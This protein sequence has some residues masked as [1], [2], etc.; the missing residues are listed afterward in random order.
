MRNHHVSLGVL[1]ALALAGAG[2]VGAS[3]QPATGTV[4]VHLTGTASSGTVYRLREAI[5]TVDGP[6]PATF[7]TEDDPTRTSLSAD[8]EPGD[9]TATVQ[10]GWHIERLDDGIATEVN[11]TLTSDNP[12]HFTVV[13]EQR[14]NVPL[15]FHVDGGDVDLTQGY[16]ITL[17]ID[18]GIPSPGDGYQV[19]DAPSQ[20][21]RLVF[22]AARQAIYAVNT[23]DQEI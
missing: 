9:Y 20:R 18:E 4:A 11:A 19:I 13:S 5:I 21:D 17:D 10:A 15:K 2:C 3:G 7:D 16:D 22:D 12:V 14:T 1:L 8:V 23:L 6:T